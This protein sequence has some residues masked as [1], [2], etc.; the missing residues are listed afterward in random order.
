MT[1]MVTDTWN[2][3]LSLASPLV[4]SLVSVGER[5]ERIDTRDDA[6]RQDRSHSRLAAHV[7][8]SSPGAPDRA[9]QLREAAREAATSER[10]DRPSRTP[11]V[12]VASDQLLALGPEKSQR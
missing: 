7:T 3:M 4:C 2:S 12:R 11:L 10:G 9:G 6:P 5:S 8:A 1:R